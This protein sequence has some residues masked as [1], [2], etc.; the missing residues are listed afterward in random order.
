MFHVRII[1]EDLTEAGCMADEV[2][3]FIEVGGVVGVEVEGVAAVVVGG[4]ATGEL[5]RTIPQLIL[6]KR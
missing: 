2:G 4:E 3:A 6:L 1:V 5:V